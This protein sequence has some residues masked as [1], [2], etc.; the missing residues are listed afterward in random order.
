[1]KLHCKTFPLA[2]AFCAGLA[3]A[4]AG[5]AAF[6]GGAEFAEQKGWAF[7]EK[8]IKGLRAEGRKIG[9]S[10]AEFGT[11]LK[12]QHLFEAVNQT[13]DL[14]AAAFEIRA[15]PTF[16]VNGQKLT[17]EVAIEEFDKTFEAPG[18]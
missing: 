1:M 10:D 12:D 13:R 14:A 4:G 18:K 8:P 7:T 16:F 5:E 15:T 2:L 11:R 3:R 17:G 9:M 6:A